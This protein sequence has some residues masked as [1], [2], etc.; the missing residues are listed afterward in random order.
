MK[1][2]EGLA[3]W[4]PVLSAPAEYRH[5]ASV[6][7]RALERACR[8]RTVLELGS[9]GGNNASHLK[10]RFEMTLVDRSPAML[11]VSR[12]LNPECAH[13]RGDMRTVRLRRTFDAV[14]L[15]DAVQYLTTALDL[16]RSMR[17]AFVHCRPGGAALFVPDAV[18]ETFRPGA[19]HGGHD[20]RG[21]ALRYLEWTGPAR[22]TTFTTEYALLV[23]S[24]HAVR[25]IH[26]RHRLGLF[27]RATWLRLL[28]DAGFRARRLR[29][30]NGGEDGGWCDAFLGVRPGRR[31]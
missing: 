31:P 4:W 6:Y 27:P 19:S 3:A 17:T 12:R 9:G 1:M 29:L 25:C 5:E 8:P 2:Y 18:R 13:A 10:K 14:F 20:G 15:H 23:R 24:G 30:R 26:D 16:G 28:R 7:A 11:R 22:G 21:R